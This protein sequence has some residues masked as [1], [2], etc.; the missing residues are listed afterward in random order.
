MM[1]DVMT[2]LVFLFPVSIVILGV[3]GIF[4]LVFGI[5]WIMRKR[6]MPKRLAV[7]TAIVLFVSIVSYIYPFRPTLLRSRQVRTLADMQF[8]R[9]VISKYQVC[10]GEY[11]GNLEVAFVET[12]KPPVMVDAWGTRFIY[13]SHG[14]SYI[15]ASLGSDGVPDV[16]D[17]WEMRAASHNAESVAG[18]WKADQIASDLGWHRQAGK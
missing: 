8:L 5:L 12:K 16:P 10:H 6:P 17:L 13:E 1:A 7:S 4:W 2:F 9:R 15:L 14:S 18:E 3:L 11:P